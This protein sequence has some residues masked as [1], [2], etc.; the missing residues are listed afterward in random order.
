M[1][2]AT[3]LFRPVGANELVL[4]RDSGWRAFPPRL[5]GQ[6]I[7]YPVANEEYA[8]QIAR[9]W[10]ARGAHG[11]GFVVRFKI[12]SEYLNAFELHQVGAKVH[13]EYWIP[14]AALDE[15]NSNIVGRIEIVA[16]FESEKK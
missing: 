11:L 12:D 3:V 8:R 15:F 6:P 1:K 10:N 16:S 4:I 7:F 9:D 14:A 5:Q 13:S 2:V